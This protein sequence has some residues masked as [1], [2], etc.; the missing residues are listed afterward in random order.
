MSPR[1]AALLMTM[2]IGTPLPDVSPSAAIEAASATSSGGASAVHLPRAGD[3]A[4]AGSRIEVGQRPAEPP[5]GTGDQ[6]PFG[7]SG[8]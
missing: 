5:P 7:V 1:I 3:H 6:A 8:A 4:E 2:S